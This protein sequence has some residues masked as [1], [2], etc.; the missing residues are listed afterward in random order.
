[1]S[2]EKYVVGL[3]GKENLKILD[4]EYLPSQL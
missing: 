4:E 3:E 1:M 2:R